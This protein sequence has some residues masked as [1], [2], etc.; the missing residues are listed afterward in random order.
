[1]SYFFCTVSVC[2]FDNLAK[3]RT[4]VAF[5]V[6][7]PQQSATWDDPGIGVIAPSD[8]VGA[9]LI[10]FIQFTYRYV[11]LLHSERRNW[12]RLASRSTVSAG[13]LLL[14]SLVSVSGVPRCRLV[15]GGPR[16]FPSFRQQARHLSSLLFGWVE[17]DCRANPTDVLY[18]TV[19]VDRSRRVISSTLTHSPVFPRSSHLFSGS[20]RLGHPCWLVP[21]RSCAGVSKPWPAGHMRPA[22]ALRPTHG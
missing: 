12:F 21:H 13:P 18:A 19:G 2:V 14:S 3:S 6:S 11:R 17:P 22:E 7:W 10:R 4:A 1:M 16:F 20:C 15:W 8:F 9:M 5:G